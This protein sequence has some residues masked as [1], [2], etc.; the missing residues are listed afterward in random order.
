MSAKCMDKSFGEDYDSNV[1]TFQ[2]LDYNSWRL[3][4][5]QYCF[6]ISKDS[7]ADKIAANNTVKELENS[8][9]DSIHLIV[10][11]DPKTSSVIGTLPAYWGIHTYSLLGPQEILRVIQGTATEIIRELLGPINFITKI[12]SYSIVPKGMIHVFYLEG[13]GSAITLPPESTIK[14]I[15]TSQTFPDTL[16]KKLTIHY[17]KVKSLTPLLLTTQTI[18]ENVYWI[19]PVSGQRLL[20]MRKIT[21]T[22]K[23]GDTLVS[24]DS[25]TFQYAIIETNGIKSTIGGL[26]NQEYTNYTY[27]VPA[28][29]IK[30]NKKLMRRESM[31]D[32][33]YRYTTTPIKW[34]SESCETSYKYN[35]EKM[36]VETTQTILISWL[37]T[38]V[39]FSHWDARQQSQI[40]TEKATKKTVETIT[41][42]PIN[43]GQT[44]VSRLSTEDNL[45]TGTSNS[46]INEVVQAGNNSVSNMGYPI[47]MDTDTIKCTLSWVSYGEIRELTAPVQLSLSDINTILTK[48]LRFLSTIKET[49]T[50]AF[51]GIVKATLGSVFSYGVLVSSSIARDVNSNSIIS[52]ITME[53]YST[54]TNSDIGVPERQF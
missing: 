21:T 24:E 44:K 38:G 20:T 13:F 28:N 22:K 25:K 27:D 53:S 19:D 52:S 4:K 46:S 10:G 32:Y 42:T 48:S 51:P 15:S 39:A 54:I 14:N 40:Q 17:N 16:V 35:G 12:A 29:S 47:E 34:K 1:G 50:L 2:L 31:K 49:T 26:N 37:T 11:G 8:G 3:Q 18:P 23:Y 41:Y 36:S 7:E 30:R 43:A 6:V 45:I 5:Y 33:Y 9:Y